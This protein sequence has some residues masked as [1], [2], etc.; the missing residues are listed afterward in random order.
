MIFFQFHFFRQDLSYVWP[1]VSSPDWCFS[2]P[3]IIIIG[4]YFSNS[5]TKH[6]ILYVLSTH[7]LTGTCLHTWVHNMQ[8]TNNKQVMK[9]GLRWMKIVAQGRGNGRSVG[10]PFGKNKYDFLADGFQEERESCK[11]VEDKMQKLW[12]P[13][14]ESLVWGIWRL[15]VSEAEWRVWEGV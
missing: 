6:K 11:G 13:T 4:F 14:V 3:R 15:R 12:E 9:M 8:L 5:F 10:L 7:S 2:L 1:C